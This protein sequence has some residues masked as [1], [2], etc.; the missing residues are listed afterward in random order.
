MQDHTYEPRRVQGPS[1]TP[2]T[3]QLH[4]NKKPS[5]PNKPKPKR[6]LDSHEYALL[7]SRR[8][9]KEIVI[10]MMT[11][12]KVIGVVTDI[13]RFSFSIRSGD[14]IECIFKHAV[15]SFRFAA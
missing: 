6:Q 10:E 3:G 14:Q 12:R 5:K 7:N 2:H 8:D 13:D 1:Y 4:L 11:G 15:S 9:G